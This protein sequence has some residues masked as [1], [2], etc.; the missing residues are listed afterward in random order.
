MFH[1]P[2]VCALRGEWLMLHAAAGLGYVFLS[3]H[4]DAAYEVFVAGDVCERLLR[5]LGCLNI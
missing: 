2:L 3:F 5:L 1:I 4:P